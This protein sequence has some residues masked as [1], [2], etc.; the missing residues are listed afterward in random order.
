MFPKWQNFV[1]SG[2]TDLNWQIYLL[3][4]PELRKKQSLARAGRTRLLFI[5]KSQLS[6]MKYFGFLQVW[7][8]VIF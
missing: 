3:E 2:N 7:T 4:I 5:A 8:F 1:K 6:E